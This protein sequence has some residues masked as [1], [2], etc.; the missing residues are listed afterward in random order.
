MADHRTCSESG[1]ERRAVTI[2]PFCAEHMRTRRYH[3]WR[4]L[5]M[6]DKFWCRVDER[7]AADCWPWFGAI[8]PSGHGHVMIPNPAG[9]KQLGVGAHVLAY[10]LSVGP[11]PGGLVIDHRCHNGSG[12]ADGSDCQHRRCCNPAHLEAVTQRENVLRG[13]GLAGLASRKTECIRGHDLTDP[14]NFKW[15]KSSHNG[16]PRRICRACLS[17]HRRSRYLRLGK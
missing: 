6:P 1:C 15:G 13:E 7:D 12:C 5:S 3:E 4:A 17:I 8:V 14:A 2:A 9:G 16:Q 11:I 10:M